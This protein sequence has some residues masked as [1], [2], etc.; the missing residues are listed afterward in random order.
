MSAVPNRLPS[1]IGTE[2]FVVELDRFQGPL[3]LLLHLIRA[4]DID[5]FDIP[6]S[7]IT[8]QFQVAVEEGIDR[9]ELDRAGEFLE[10]AAT[11]IRIKAQL[12]LPRHD[13]EDWGEDPRAELVRRLLEYEFFQEVAH[14]LSDSEAERRRHHGKGY[15]EP[16]Q[17]PASV[18]GELT[19]TLEE[20]LGIALE[21][22]EHIPEQI[23]VAP[24]RV[25][26]VEEKVSAIRRHLS[27]T[28]RLLFSRLFRSWNDR[29]HVI[30]ALLAC[31]EM[32]RQQV[33]RIEQ[34]KRFG[35]IWI[36]AAEET[37]PAEDEPAEKPAAAGE[38]LASVESDS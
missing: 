11:L 20:F 5:I 26:T 22:P 18:R 24:V 36:F 28:K 34:V 27:R 4:Q 29:Q 23:H 12:L 9:L 21:L 16:R 14:V 15:V 7:Q 2:S 10:L 30:A 32:A 25:V 17:R 8:A 6:I 38:E 19:T 35:S 1:Q 31:L 3:D 33:L 37:S 13:D